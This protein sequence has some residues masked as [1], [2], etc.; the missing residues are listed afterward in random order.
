ME[1]HNPTASRVYQFVHATVEALGPNTV[2]TS[3]SSS[4]HHGEAY[5]FKRLDQDRGWD[6][7]LE[8]TWGM[9]C[10]LGMW[11]FKIAVR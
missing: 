5:V 7:T 6:Q 9:F 3:V 4:A 11:Q 10:T 8:N 1:W 2:R